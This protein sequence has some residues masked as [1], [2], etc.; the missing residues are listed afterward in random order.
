M[1]KRSRSEKEN[2]DQ[3]GIGKG[4]KN[5]KDD[6][7]KDKKNNEDTL[8]NDSSN[9]GFGTWLRSTDGVEMMRLFVIANAILV[10]VTMAW[11]NM[12]EALYI[13]KDYITGE[14]E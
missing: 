8:D 7:E 11:P 12:Q 2:R 6:K 5:E 9:Q 4:G 14:E 13:L 3:Q 10:F 1:K